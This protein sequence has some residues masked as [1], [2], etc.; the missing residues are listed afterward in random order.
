MSRNGRW[1]PKR[2]TQQNKQRPGLGPKPLTQPVRGWVRE[3]FVSILAINIG[4]RNHRRY[5]SFTLFSESEAEVRPRRV[6][7][8]VRQTDEPSEGDTT[9]HRT[10]RQKF[11]RLLFIY[12]SMILTNW[13]LQPLLL[14]SLILSTIV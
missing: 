4:I 5:R 7:P 3:L 13:Q 11:L 10:G 8:S 14:F 2:L 6:G 12:L 1:R 9:E